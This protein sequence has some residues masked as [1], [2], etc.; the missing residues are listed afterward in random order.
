MKWTSAYDL[1]V[2]R[3]LKSMLRAPSS[4]AHFEILLVASWFRRMSPSGYSV[5]TEI[6][7]SW[8]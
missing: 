1:M 4:T 7:Y 6:E 2:V 3:G 8:K 5:T